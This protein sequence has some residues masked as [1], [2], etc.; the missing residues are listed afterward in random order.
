MPAGDVTLIPYTPVT[1][2]QPRGPNHVQYVVVCW[3]NPAGTAAPAA[4]AE[5][6]AVVVRV[7]SGAAAPAADDVATRMVAAVNAAAAVRRTPRRVVVFM[8]RMVH[9]QRPTTVRRNRTQC[10]D[11]AQTCTLGDRTP[12]LCTHI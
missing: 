6:A 3:T 8:A 5:P 1:A 7:S 11:E 4:A 2:V 9:R 10:A 12:A